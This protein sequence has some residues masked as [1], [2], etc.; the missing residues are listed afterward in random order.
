[1][2]RGDWPRV[3]ELAEESLAGHRRSGGFPK[4]EAQSLGSLAAVARFDGDL[5]LALELLRES[6]ALAEQAGFR[7]WVAGM[8][9][10][11]GEVS[12]EL[13]RLDEARS[14]VCEALRITHAMH[15]RRGVV[16]ELKLLSEVSA[17]AGDSLGAGVCLGAVEAEQGRAPVGPWLFGS[18][19]GGQGLRPLAT[20][21]DFDDPE[22]ERGREEGRRLE[23]DAAV[24]TALG[25]A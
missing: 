21:V 3:R 5:E 4:G 6:C 2:K 23:L 12:L 18:L 14:S 1:M 24:A 7:W 22:L 9:A 17:A 8:L 11:I 20:R 25:D 16:Y 13:G 15:D 10:N 19:A